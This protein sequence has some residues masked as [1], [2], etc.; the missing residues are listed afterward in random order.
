MVA[1][2]DRGKRVGGA[3]YLTVDRA[4]A[5]LTPV[6]ANAQALTAL[7]S[8]DGLVLKVDS[9]Q[10]RLSFLAYPGLAQDAFP[11]L[12]QSWTI[13]LTAQ[14]CHHRSYDADGNPPVLHRQELVLGEAHPSYSILAALTAE[15]ERLGLFDDPSII[16]HRQQWQEELRARGVQ[17]DGLRLVRL[18]ETDRGDR[19]DVARYRT[20]IGRRTLSTPVQVL[21]RHGFV[22]S[23]RTFFDYGCGRGDDIALLASEGVNTAGW[24]PHFRPDDPLRTADAVNLGFVLNVIE[25]LEERREAL[26]RAWMLC[27]QVMSV[28]ALIGGRTA[29]ERFRL[30]R[31]GVLTG[32]GTFQK[33]FTH[34]ELGGYIAEVLGR[35]AV[36]V[37]PGIYLV[38]RSDEAEQAF[39][40]ERER[41]GGRPWRGS[42]PSAPRPMRPPRERRERA[43][44]SRPVSRWD[45][46]ADLVDEFATV[47][48]SLGRLPEPDEWAHW[49]DLARDVGSPKSV[50]RHLQRRDGDRAW[51]DAQKRRRD[52]LR[53]WLAIAAFEPR[54][55]FAAL[56]LRLQRDVRALFGSYDRAADEGRKLLFELGD[57][58]RLQADCR[59]ALRAG[60]VFESLSRQG[61][62]LRPERVPE[63]SPR[64]RVFVGAAG[65]LCGGLVGAD[66]V[67]LAPACSTVSL[68]LVDVPD[69]RVA[70]TIIERIDVELRNRRVVQRELGSMAFPAER[71]MVP[72]EE[73]TEPDLAAPEAQE[74]AV[75]DQDDDT[76]R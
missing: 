67:R 31:D 57:T 58:H 61:Y 69:P 74:P 22:G 33:Y 5:E 23:E 46:H 52:D 50:L 30:F 43:P 37:A 55:S 35:E 45:Y 10:P 41:V 44:S 16:G 6:I 9:T 59:D 53:V 1:S 14:F 40:E 38:F 18:R 11:I 49:R 56:P 25:D 76:A 13:D 42:M 20:A 39:L 54:R 12:A 8:L 24:D 28:S 66:L 70:G 63:L 48:W 62:D 32:I 34:A 47:A 4:P 7:P 64:L 15:T 17:V 68:L 60:I 71:V 75:N 72:A 51:Q 26:A 29:Y 73:S 3:W 2:L 36:G 19:P 21:W 65:R 27:R